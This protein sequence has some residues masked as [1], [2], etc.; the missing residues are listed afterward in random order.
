MDAV[1]TPPDH[2]TRLELFTITRSNDPTELDSRSR[3][4]DRLPGQSREYRYTLQ[5]RTLL[6][7]R[8]ESPIVSVAIRAVGPILGSYGQSLF[9]TEVTLDGDESDVFGFSSPLRGKM[10]L[11]S[12][13]DPTSA[14]PGQGLVY[15]LGAGMRLIMGDGNERS[16]VF[17]KAADVEQALEEILDRRLRRPLRFEPLLEWSSGL[18]ASL[19]LQLDYLLRDL[20]RADGIASNPVALASMADLLIVLMLRG[21]PNNYSDQL[22]PGPRIAMPA[23][24]FRAEEF[25]RATCATPVRI[26][27]IAAAAGC[28]VRTLNAVFQRFRGHVPLAA[29]NN[30]RLEQVHAKLIGA[31]DGAAIGVVARRYG[32]TNPHRFNL[33]FRRRFGEAPRDVVR[34]TLR[35]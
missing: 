1:P 35:L 15:R 28:S 24:V 19:K 9:A 29:L 25:M 12:R 30:I 22:E 4:S 2:D 14:G 20:A 23:Y 3:M 26:S 27:D 31:A 10:T 11:S 18:A 5:D 33:A 32:F 8:F 7:M 6:G 13:D 16:N 21:A 34:R 17:I